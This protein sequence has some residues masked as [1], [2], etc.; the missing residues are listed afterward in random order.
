MFA[1]SRTNA[2]PLN[3]ISYPSSVIH[4]PMSV[5]I[6]GYKGSMSGSR[7]HCVRPQMGKTEALR[8]KFLFV[9]CTTNVI[10]EVDRMFT[11]IIRCVC[12]VLRMSLVMQ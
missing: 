9:D 10:F 12:V 11:G 8:D 5:D 1:Q 7:L 2:K 4:F 6:R 3:P